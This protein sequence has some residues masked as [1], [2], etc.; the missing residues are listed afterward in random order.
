MIKQALAKIPDKDLRKSL[1]I[2]YQVDKTECENVLYCLC[3]FSPEQICEVFQKR[4]PISVKR[5]V[6]SKGK[7][8]VEEISIKIV[9]NK[10]IEFII[11]NREGKNSLQTIYNLRPYFNASKV[12]EFKSSYFY[13]K[14]SPNKFVGYAAFEQDGAIKVQIDAYSHGVK[15]METHRTVSLE[16][17]SER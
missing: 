16:Q 13:T 8:I 6:K 12:D 17:T 3:A 15:I 7:T 2:L 1:Q 10:D 9:Y 11:I 4:N 5:K 14:N